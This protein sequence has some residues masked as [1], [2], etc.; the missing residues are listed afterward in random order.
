MVSLNGSLNGKDVSNA[1]RYDLID[2]L[3]DGKSGNIVDVINLVSD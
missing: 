1:I 2:V 3:V